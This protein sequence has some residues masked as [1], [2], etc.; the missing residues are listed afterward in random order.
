[1]GSAD[2]VG[3]LTTDKTSKKRIGVYL[4]RDLRC[5]DKIEQ[6]SNL[7]GRNPDVPRQRM[8]ERMRRFAR[9]GLG[10]HSVPTN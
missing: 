9:E 3:L 4:C 8:M 1:M 5:V 10:I 6:A 7:A 2:E